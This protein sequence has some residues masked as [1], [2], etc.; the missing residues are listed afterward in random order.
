MRNVKYRADELKNCRIERD[1]LS[2][3]LNAMS[4]RS[5]LFLKSCNRTGGKLQRYIKVI[6]KSYVSGNLHFGTCTVFFLL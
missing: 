1:V 6:A 5:M 4:H 3:R 2:G